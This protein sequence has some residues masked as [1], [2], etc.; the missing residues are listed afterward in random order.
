MNKANNIRSKSVKDSLESYN[1]L[2]QSLKENTKNAVMDILSETV[3]ETYAK[4]L[5]EDEDYEE[6]EVKDVE[7]PETDD[8][9]L[10]DSE[11]IL[12]TEDDESSSEADGEN[13]DDSETETTIVTTKES[14]DEGDEDEWS[15]FEQ[16]KIGDNE[17]DFSDAD[18]EAAIKVYK[19]LKDDDQLLVVKDG[20]NKLNIKDNE[21]NSEYLVD[22]GEGDKEETEIS[23]LNDDTK[24][25]ESKER[26]GNSTLYENDSNVGYTDNYQKNDVLDTKG[27]PV[28]DDKDSRDWGSKGLRKRGGEKRWSGKTGSKQENQPFNTE[29]DKSDDSI[30]FEVY[31][32]DIEEGTNVGGFVQQN[33]TTKS[34]VPN[35]SGRRARNS[36]KGTVVPR[37]S[38]ETERKEMTNESIFRKAQKIFK[39]NTELKKTLVQFKNVLQ[40]AAVTNVNLGQIIKLITE[41]TTS[42][43]E[44]KEIIARFGKEAKTVEQSKNL[45]ESISRTLKK[46]NKMNITESAEL[47]TVSS[48][49]IN[50]TQIYKSDDI[51]KSL[52]LMHK[53]C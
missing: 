49:Q 46:S 26:V 15:S 44:K 47:N 30:I 22:L 13:N 21:T 6:D 33:S 31:A 37:Y 10:E 28:T 14:G 11:D 25:E 35:S 48:K 9:N 45:Y 1:A 51:L 42:Q 36:G 24:V 8:T 29:K 38:Q 52:D 34:H 50:E 40:E 7:N 2:S 20:E 53:L 41:N 43:D 19:L 23:T 4:I 12:S 18:E 17:Y 32:D 3:R 5:A 39:E 27:L 16:F